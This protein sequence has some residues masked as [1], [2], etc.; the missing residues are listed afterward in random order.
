[1][2]PVVADLVVRLNPNLRELYE[3]R[4]A[5]RE[6]NGGLSRELAEAMALLDVIRMHP[7]E[8][9]ACLRGSGHLI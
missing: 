6:F 7:D 4:A 5:V 9:C 8:A 2:D 3:E 1:M